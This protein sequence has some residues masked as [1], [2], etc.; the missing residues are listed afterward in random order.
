MAASY[1]EFFPSRYV[2]AEDLGNSRPIVTIRTVTSE[3]FPDGRK[4]VVH[5]VEPNIKPLVLS[6]RINARSIA[7]I[8]GTDD[9][10]KWGGVQIQLYASTTEVHGEMK[11]CIRIEPVRRASEPRRTNETDSDAIGF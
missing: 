1:T 9:Y 10:T 11:A 3:D 7:Q 6:A 8:A 4:P 5:F 2:K